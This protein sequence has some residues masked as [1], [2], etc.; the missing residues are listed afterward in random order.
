[1]ILGRW[2]GVV[3][4][5]QVEGW[6]EDF[7][8]YFLGFSHWF[9]RVDIRWRAL[10]YLRGLMAPIERRNGWTL[11][12]QAGDQTPDAMQGLLCSP[13]FDR[14]AVRDEVRSGVVAAIGDPGG[15]LIADKT[16]FVKKGKASAGVQRQYT[17]TSGK[18]DNC[19]IGVFL[20]YASPAG[21]ALIDR[22]LYLP[23]SW[24]TDRD[25]CRKAKV[26]DEVEFATKPQQART[27]LERAV[28]AGYRSPGSPPTR[29]MG[30]TRACVSGANSRTSPM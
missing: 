17:G 26:P 6:D 25:R 21:R 1:M 23:K 10:K 9:S 19:Q 11:A 16:G 29:P 15:V 7:R 14:D 20:A 4:V 18:V 24:I 8:E 30:R 12:E 13:C 5:E 22:E 27:M 3:T 28:E 2:P